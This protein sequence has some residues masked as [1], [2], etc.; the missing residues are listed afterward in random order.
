[1]TRR[2]S[3]WT[4]DNAWHRINNGMFA[5][6]NTISETLIIVPINRSQTLVRSPIRRT[7]LRIESEVQTL[8]RGECWYNVA[9]FRA[10]ILPLRTRFV[11]RVTPFCRA[12]P[13]ADATNAALDRT[14]KTQWRTSS[15]SLQYVLVA[16]SIL[17]YKVPFAR[18]WNERAKDEGIQHQSRAA[19]VG[20]LI[21]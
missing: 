18:T 2:G 14:K 13:K 9:A 20:L 16:A 17:R 4:R 1:M 5:S 12:R 11:W 6:P 8:D 21:V 15:A 19:C 3:S 10:P 7:D